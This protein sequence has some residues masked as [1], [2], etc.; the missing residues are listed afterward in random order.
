MTSTMVA[1]IDFEPGCAQICSIIEECGYAHRVFTSY[2]D[3]RSWFVEHGVPCVVADYNL[4][5]T[6]RESLFDWI[7]AQ[8]TFTQ[9]IFVGRDNRI[10]DAIESMKRGAHS[11]LCKPIEKQV[12][13]AT[14][15]VAIHDG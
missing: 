4:D 13:E 10:Q 14:L 9:V 1:V 2:E 7:S 12:L 15:D 5:P 6:S 3:F 8:G 11:F